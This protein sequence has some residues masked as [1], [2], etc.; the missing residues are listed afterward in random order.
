MGNI[1]K[2]LLAVQVFITILAFNFTATADDNGSKTTRKLAIK[3]CQ[4]GILR[5]AH[6]PASVK[7]TDTQPVLT[8]SVSEAGLVTI[9]LTMEIRA[10]NGYNALRKGAVTCNFFEFGESDLMLYQVIQSE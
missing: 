8:R 1:V 4:R 2:K 6:D 10:K 7:F 9:E 3:E 5:D